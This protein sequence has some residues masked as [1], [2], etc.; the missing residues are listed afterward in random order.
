MPRRPSYRPASGRTG[1]AFMLARGRHGVGTLPRPACLW[2]GDQLPHHMAALQPPEALVD[3]LELQ[4]VADEVVELQ[5][6]L[7]P[8]RQQPRHVRAEMVG[9]HGGAL[10]LP[11]AQEVEAVQ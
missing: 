5:L 6:A 7:L 3:L 1:M 10:D 11:L 9:A 4:R 2:E 8:E